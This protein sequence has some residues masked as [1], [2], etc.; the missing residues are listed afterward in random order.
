[1]CDESQQPTDRL[2]LK[3]YVQHCASKYC[4][5]SLLT[6]VWLLAQDGV[7]LLECRILGL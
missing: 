5:P 2:G 4:S 1:M 7:V 3:L 6:H